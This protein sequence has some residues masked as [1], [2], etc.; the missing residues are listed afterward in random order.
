M[1]NLFDLSNV[2]VDPEADAVCAV[3]RLDRIERVAADIRSCFTGRILS[4]DGSV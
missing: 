4:V 2:G 3:V 1:T